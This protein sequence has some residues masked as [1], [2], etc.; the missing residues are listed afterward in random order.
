MDLYCGTGTIGLFLA[1]K[2]KKVIGIEEN[3]A[4]I[5][6]AKINAAQNNISNIEFMCGRVKNILKFNTFSPDV[7]VVDPPRS[8]MVPK[9]LKRIG[10]IE[11]PYIIY[12]SCNPVTM[13]RDI[14]DLKAHNY[15]LQSLQPVDMF[16][17]TFHME[18]ICLLKRIN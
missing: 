10:E 8:G 13:A 11:C 12:V 16:P 3:P 9:A 5:E 17:N 15:V 18:T 2:V 7:I 4:A 14:N 1:S 6:D